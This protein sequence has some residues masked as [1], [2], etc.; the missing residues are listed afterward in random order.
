VLGQDDKTKQ[1][2]KTPLVPILLGAL[3]VAIAGSAVVYLQSTSAQTT[4]VV[5]TEAATAYLPNLD[6]NNVEMEANEDSLGLTL[7]QVTGD[8]ANLGDTSVTI[9]EA[10]CIFRDVN[11]LEIER[12][13]STF[14]NRRTGPLDPGE[15]QDFRMAFDDPPD[16]WNQILPDL[17][18]AQIQFND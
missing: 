16:G 3:A 9:V 13:R 4:E 12:Q 5:L 11:G 6:L 14:V 8:I 17:F 10:N 18:I 2:A 7:L 15:T 1:S